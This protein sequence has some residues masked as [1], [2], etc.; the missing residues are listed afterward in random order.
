MGPLEFR[1]CLPSFT[2]PFT[3]NAPSPSEPVGHLKL[4][5]IF[6]LQF[7][8]RSNQVLGSRR[9]LVVDNLEVMEIYEQDLK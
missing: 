5:I 1:N 8:L 7:V 6:I 9:S 3:C 4:K 2:V